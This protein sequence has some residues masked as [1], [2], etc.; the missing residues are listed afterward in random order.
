MGVLWI[1]AWSPIVRVRAW[2]VTLATG[3]IPLLTHNLRMGTSDS[4]L[5]LD[6]NFGRFSSQ[7]T[8]Q[9]V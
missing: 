1:Q 6:M 9:Q 2:Q 7:S 5:I 3:Y 4:G 8:G